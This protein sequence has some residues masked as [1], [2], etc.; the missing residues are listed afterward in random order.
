MKESEDQMYEAMKDEA[1]MIARR[2]MNRVKLRLWNL[3]NVNPDHSTALS[4]VAN[5]I[6]DVLQDRDN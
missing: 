6:D 4:M 5:A 2:Y 1:D 3:A